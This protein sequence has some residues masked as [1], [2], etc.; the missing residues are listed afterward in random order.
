MRHSFKRG[1]RS[2]GGN[3]NRKN[4]DVNSDGEIVGAIYLSSKDCVR[5][6]VNDNIFKYFTVLLA[7]GYLF[8]YALLP[9]AGT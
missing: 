6:T 5:V 8:I 7:Q 2:G 4:G 1:I 9:A 3:T